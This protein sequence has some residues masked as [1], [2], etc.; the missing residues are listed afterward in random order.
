LR[1]LRKGIRGGENAEKRDFFTLEIPSS[2]R[3]RDK[4]RRGRE[5]AQFERTGRKYAVRERES[6]RERENEEVGEEEVNE[7]SGTTFSLE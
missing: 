3:K 2:G 1:R 5:S 6:E 4:F 7:K